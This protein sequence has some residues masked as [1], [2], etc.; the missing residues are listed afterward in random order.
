MSSMDNM[1]SGG[2]VRKSIF[3]LGTSHRV[4]GSPNFPNSVEDPGYPQKLR[5]II[6][7]ESIDFIFE[8][9]SGCG[10]TTAERLADSLRPIRY[11]DIDPHPAVAHEFGIVSATGQAFPVNIS[12]EECIEEQSKR[13]KLW[14][15]RIVEQDFKSGLVIC[16]YLHTLSIAFRLRSA[17]FGVKYDQYIPHERLCTRLHQ[18]DAAP[19]IMP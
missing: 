19:T 18:D 15:E 17:G 8:E 7:A 11:L 1:N 3:V 13:E 2:A 10:R 5:A 16:G 4:Q 6:S 9:A 14:C 12:E